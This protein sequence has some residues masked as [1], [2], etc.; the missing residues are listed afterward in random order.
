[1]R[2]RFVNLRAR[3]GDALMLGYVLQIGSPATAQSAATLDRFVGSWQEDESKA[4]LGDGG[5]LVFRA[6]VSGQIE[7]LRGGQVSPQVQPVIFDCQP[8]VVDANGRTTAWTQQN[9]TTFRRVSADKNGRVFLTRTLRLSADGKTLT[10][11]NSVS[12]AEL[13]PKIETNTYQREDGQAGLVGTWRLKS[14]KSNRP[15][16]IKIER[17]RGAGLRVIRTAR[18]AVE[19]IPLNG[20]PG[21][22]TGPDVISGSSS[23]SKIL[24]DG[25]IEVT[26]MRGGSAMSRTIYAVSPDGRIMTI[27][28]TGLGK[29]ANG[30]PSIGV[31]VKQ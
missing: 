6:T 19:E 1:M 27:T 7:E 24:P 15:G 5:A 4:Q 23:M 3:I 10:E 25:S 28:S 18:E 26:A 22:V 20:Q 29:N 9:D 2:L 12:P 13:S 16:V 11:E 8:R 14:F 30:K 17:N 31:F 21:T